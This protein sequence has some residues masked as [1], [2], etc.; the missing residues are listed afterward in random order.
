MGQPSEIRGPEFEAKLMRNDDRKAMGV[1]DA[2]PQVA[3]LSSIRLIMQPDKD[4]ISR[5]WTLAQPIVET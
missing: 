2:R 1:S 5:K 3:R 4:S